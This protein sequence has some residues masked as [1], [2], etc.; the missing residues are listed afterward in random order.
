[1]NTRRFLLTAVLVVLS[2]TVAVPLAS[3]ATL[4]A[5][6]DGQPMPTL[7]LM[8]E[9]TTPAVV[10]IATESRVA[11]RRNPLL[12]DPFFRHFFRL[13]FAHGPP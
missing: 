1:M 13:L 9:R 11:L 4:P 10:N 5:A 3:P 7:A 8:L 6:V 12:D 2:L